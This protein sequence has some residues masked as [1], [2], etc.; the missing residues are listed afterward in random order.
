MN[1][2][3]YNN[4]GMA[5]FATGFSAVLEK[6]QQQNKQTN[7]QTLDEFYL[8]HIKKNETQQNNTPNRQKTCQKQP[9]MLNGNFK[10]NVVI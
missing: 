6:Q 9:H 3:S 7:K 8:G 5:R 4:T 2:V 1:T 10:L